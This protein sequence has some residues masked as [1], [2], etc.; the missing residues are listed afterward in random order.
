MPEAPF[1]PE[2]TPDLKYI[3]PPAFDL[4]NSMDM[5]DMDIR[6]AKNF[7]Y[8][9]VSFMDYQIGRITDALKAKGMYD[10]TAI[11]FIADHGETLGDYRHAGK[12]TML[13][14]ANRIPFILRVPG[15][16]GGERSDP[17]SLVDVAPTLLSLFGVDYDPT[18]FDGIDILSGKHSEVYSQYECGEK[19]CYMV[20]GAEDKLIYN[21]SNNKYAYFAECPEHIDRY[22]EGGERVEYLKTLLDAHIAADRCPEA[23]NPNKGA[24]KAEKKEKIHGFGHARMDHQARHDEEAALIPPQYKIDLRRFVGDDT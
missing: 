12:R 13:S 10:D 3:F 16:E 24:G 1:V 4:D 21:A 8:A 23:K 11:L 7:Y 18:E 2:E 15:M 17:V 19:A 14:C 9:C 6:R 5:T 20:A 22:A